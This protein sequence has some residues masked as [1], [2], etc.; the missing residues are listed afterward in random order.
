MAGRRLSTTP[1]R[2]TLGEV[3]AMMRRHAELLAELMG[4][5][6]GLRDMRK[7]MAW[8]LKGFVVGQEVRAALGMV[9]SMAE[10]DELL[11]RLDGTQ[12]FPDQEIGTPRGR[13]GS[14]RRGALPEGGLD[15]PREEAGDLAGAEVRLSGGWGGG[16]LPLAARAGSGQPH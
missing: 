5:E 2:P 8:Y 15:D 6:R 9:S 12:P 13:Q 7:H 14:P 10:L 1:V 16:F 3:A 11:A 4:E